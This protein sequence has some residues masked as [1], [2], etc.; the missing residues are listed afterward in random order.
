MSPHRTADKA[1]NKIIFENIC[2][3]AKA[4]PSYRLSATL[5]GRFWEEIEKVI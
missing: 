4:V 1:G 3:L 5:E 2:H